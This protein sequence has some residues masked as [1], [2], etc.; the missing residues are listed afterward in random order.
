MDDVAYHD[1]IRDPVLD[2]PAG[3]L[4][5]RDVLQDAVDV[6]AVEIRIDFRE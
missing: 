3:V 4:N 5:D 6:L 2:I 1:C